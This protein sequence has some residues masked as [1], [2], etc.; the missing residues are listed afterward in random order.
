MSIRRV[1]LGKNAIS[2]SFKESKPI[3]KNDE[4]E[5]E[6]FLFSLSIVVTLFTFA[7]AFPLPLIL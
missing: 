7:I 1:T 2:T 5:T 3:V 6:F 4:D